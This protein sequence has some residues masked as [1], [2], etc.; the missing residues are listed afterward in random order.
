MLA[1]RRASLNVSLTESSIEMQAVVVVELIYTVVL[2]LEVLLVEVAMVFQVIGFKVVVVY[3]MHIMVV[4]IKMQNL[5]Q[6][7]KALVAEAVIVQQ[8]VKLHLVVP[9]DL[10]SLLQEKPMLEVLVEYGV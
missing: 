3:H 6:L 5:V 9:E 1:D 7:I 2:E 8:L 4:Q 10:V